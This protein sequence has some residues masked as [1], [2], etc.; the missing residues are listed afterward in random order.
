VTTEFGTEVEKT[1]EEAEAE[2]E[3]E[4]EEKDVLVSIIGNFGKYQLLNCLLMGFTG[5]TFSWMNF[6]T[7]F[8]TE[9]TEY[10][11]TKVI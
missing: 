9:D 6:G 1:E 7:K 2:A 11:C 10:W 3:A 5:I 8:L 4:A